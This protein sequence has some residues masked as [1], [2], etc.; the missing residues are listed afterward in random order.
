MNPTYE[1]F[2]TQLSSQLPDAVP[3]F[4]DL[5]AASPQ[6]ELS[7]FQDKFDSFLME[8]ALAVIENDTIDLIA[9]ERITETL[10]E[11]FK[12]V[13]EFAPEQ[14]SLIYAATHYFFETEDA[15][16]DKSSAEGF[17]DDLIVVN[18]MFDVIGK[19]E[20]QIKL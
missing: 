8:I 18:T 19:P 17:Q 14:Q 20:L 4:N 3:F 1:T 5:F 15:V 12:E 2:S 9:A 16:A 11:L 13:N 7:M 10:R 6:F